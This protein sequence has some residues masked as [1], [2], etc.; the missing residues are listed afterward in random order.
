MYPLLF[1]ALILAAGQDLRAQN[2]IQP[3]QAQAAGQQPI[4]GNIDWTTGVLTVYGEGIAS[5][6]IQNPAQRRLLGFRAA[7]ATAYRNLL[8]LVGQVHIDASTTVGE[9]MVAS[10]SI[11]TRVSG[12]IRGA[13]LVPGSQQEKDGVFQVALTL[14]LQDDLAA[15]FLSSARRSPA[16]ALPAETPTYLP[17]QTYTGL[18]IDA[19]GLPLK[20]SMA[21]RL[22]S[23]GGNELFNASGVDLEYARQWGVVGYDR[24]LERAGRSDRVGGATARPLVIKAEKAAGQY[25][26]DAVI[27]NED[28][29]RV[30]M[31]DKHSPFL[32]QC[33]VIFVLGPAPAH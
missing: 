12:L 33:R 31:A 32:A 10:D 23:T 1:I 6:D 9:A 4:E 13:R 26:S 7:K 17:P 28:A 27:S 2:V 11:R 3:L 29:V 16:P 21:P 24:D 19:R 14:E 5:A 15:T 18:I 20:P 8:E 25:S 30:Q 22:L